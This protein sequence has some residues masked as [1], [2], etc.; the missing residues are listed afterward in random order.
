MSRILIV[1]D[2]RETCR[3]IAEL[4]EHAGSPIRAGAAKPTD[5]L[6]LARPSRSICVI[7]DINLNADLSGLRRAA[8][9]QT[10]E[11]V[12]AGLLISGFGTLETA[13]DAVRAGAFD[14]IS[15][16]FNIARDE[17]D[18]RTRAG[19]TPTWPATAAHSRST[20]V[21]GCSAAPRH[22]RVYKQIARAADSEAP[23]LITGE[24]GTGKELVARAIH[25]HGPRAAPSVRAGQLRRDPET[26]LES[27]LFG[28][29][30][31]VVHRRRSPTA[32]ASS[33]RRTAARS[34][35]TR[36]ARCRR[37]SRSSCCGCSRKA[38]SGRSAARRAIR[39]DVA[40]RRRDQ[41][42]SRAS[43]RRAA[44]PQGSLLPAQ[45]HR[46]SSAAA[47]RSPRGHPAADRRSFCSARARARRAAGRA[48]AR[49]ARSAHRVSTGRAT[50][51]SS[52]TRSSGWSSSAADRRSSAEDLPSPSA[53]ARA[54]MHGGLFADLPTLDE[55]ERR[56]VLHVLD[57]VGGNRT[58]AASAR[59]RSPHALSDG[60]GVRARGE[61]RE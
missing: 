5:A 53:A 57:A 61:R 40:C 25:A 17:G 9:L 47:A 34:F 50:C 30:R 59:H 56:Y 13:I 41:R 45:R 22:A 2:D 46:D 20:A 28:H 39:V 11:P 31:G 14:Y 26:L 49:R 55:L 3:F 36:S 48:V 29:V 12:R 43:S 38:R 24:S 16:P 7:S 35:S 44:L 19:E 15:K 23:V 37:P 51:A 54:G 32:R 60:G 42:R 6:R 58:R 1:D 8:D 18:G 21:A 33:S 27:E 52:R 4:L 10:G